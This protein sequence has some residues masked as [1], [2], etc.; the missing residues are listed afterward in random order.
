MNHS[1]EEIR[2]AA[3]EVLSRRVDT[4]NNLDSFYS[5]KIEVGKLIDKYDGKVLFDIQQVS[6]L[7]LP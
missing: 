6:L 4:R 1:Y 7:I 3:F 2:S 5:L